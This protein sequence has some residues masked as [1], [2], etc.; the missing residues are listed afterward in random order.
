[1]FRRRPRSADPGDPASRPADVF[2]GLR[3]QIFS[4]DPADVGLHAPLWGCVME[5]GYPE[6]TATLV[7]LADGTTSLYT[8][9]GFGI[10]GGHGHESVVRANSELLRLLG[11][12]LAQMA[13]S[14][15]QSLPSGGRTIIRALTTTGQR[16]FG[17]SEN[18]LGEG[19]SPMSPVFHRAHAVITQLRLID[20]AR[21]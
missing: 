4:L 9:S 11:Q 3:Q 16:T 6:G 12:H 14:S 1:M 19:R 10:I 13:P 2:L 20:E 5:T 15:D 17:D 7:C 21:R 18:E 8:S